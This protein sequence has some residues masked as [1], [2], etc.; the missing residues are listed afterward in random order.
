MGT[1][2][3]CLLGLALLASPLAQAATDACAALTKFRM[4]DMAVTIDKAVVVPTGIP[5]PVRE[6]IAP[7]A[8]Q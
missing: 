5:A 8:R 6:S 2:F 4:P 3:K 1:P 7:A